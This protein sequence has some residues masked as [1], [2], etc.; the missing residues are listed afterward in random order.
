MNKLIKEIK[1]FLFPKQN[2]NQPKQNTNQEDLDHEYLS[3]TEE[4]LFKKFCNEKFSGSFSEYIQQRINIIKEK[5]LDPINLKM[6]ETTS[7]KEKS[8]YKNYLDENSKYYNDLIKIKES[9]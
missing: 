7:E 1:S 8:L 2:T 9:L 3:Y 6:K 4:L 5:V